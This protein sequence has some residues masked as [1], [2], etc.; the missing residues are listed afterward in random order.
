V[1][2]LL[3]DPSFEAHAPAWTLGLRAAYVSDE[4]PVYDGIAAVLMN[5][6][7]SDFGPTR[8][9][10]Y[11]RQVLATSSLGETVTPSIWIYKPSGSAGHQ[12]NDFELRIS[13]TSYGDPVMTV[14]AFDTLTIPVDLWA[15]VQAEPF[16]LPCDT[17]TLEWRLRFPVTPD[18]GKSLYVDVA[19]VLSQEANM[20]VMLMELPLRAILATLQA[21]L[22]TEIGYVNTEANDGITCPAVTHWYCWDRERAQ[23][24]KAEVEVFE[25]GQGELEE[26]ASQVST[27]SVGA[28]IPLRSSW[29]FTVRLNYA[30]RSA[31]STSAMRVLGWRYA[32]AI[33]RCL[34]NVPNLGQSTIFATPGIPVATLVPTDD[35]NDVRTFGRVEVQV[36]VSVHESSVG[37]TVLG[38]GTRPSAILES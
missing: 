12:D 7:N 35:P 24:E 27:W 38:G 28:R 23:P 17:P 4:S 22:S 37:E 20:A 33:M 30:N 10:A 2:E 13:L 19:S 16:V 1:S 26:W 9:D 21:N 3:V 32:A 29:I 5:P 8:L 34:R 25:T 6:I 11:I 31:L 36:Q 14:Q 18:V 15:K